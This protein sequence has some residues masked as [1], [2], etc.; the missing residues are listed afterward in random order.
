MVQYSFISEVINQAAKTEE[1]QRNMWQD[2]RL[3][4]VQGKVMIITKSSFPI[5]NVNWKSY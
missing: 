4:F 5:Q 2:S 3:G 1:M